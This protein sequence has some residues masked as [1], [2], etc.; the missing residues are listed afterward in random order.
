MAVDKVGPDKDFQDLFLKSPLGP[1]VL[2]R[3]LDFC[4]FGDIAPDPTW[5][6]AQNF[7]K[8][9]MDKC[10][11]SYAD[12]GEKLVRALSGKRASPEEPENEDGTGSD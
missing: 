1:K 10:G 2:G 11:L 6:E 7:M 12:R 9:I 5:R 3:M 8:I 4:D